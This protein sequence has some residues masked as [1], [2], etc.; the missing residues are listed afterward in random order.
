MVLL[1]LNGIMSVSKTI[2]NNAYLTN[3]EYILILTMMATVGTKIKWMKG[4]KVV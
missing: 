3:A 4:R 2:A 1:A